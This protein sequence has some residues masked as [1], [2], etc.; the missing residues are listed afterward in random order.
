MIWVKF[1]YVAGHLELWSPM[2]VPTIRQ[3]SELGEQ[4]RGGA[5]STRRAEEDDLLNIEFPWD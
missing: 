4:D 2:T 5:V 3:L 1:R